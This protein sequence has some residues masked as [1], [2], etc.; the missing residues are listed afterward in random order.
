VIRTKKQS[1]AK[2]TVSIYIREEIF[3]INDM[4]KPIEMRKVEVVSL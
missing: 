3:K 1:G 2:M 4:I